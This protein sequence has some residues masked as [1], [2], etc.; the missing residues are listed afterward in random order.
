MNKIIKI[1]L[2]TIVLFVLL[3]L[4]GVHTPI[5]AKYI[6]SQIEPGMTR[7]EVVSIVVTNSI[8]K[9]DAC[10][11]EVDGDNK[12]FISKRAICNPP[13]ETYM[14]SGQTKGIK[15]TVLFMGPGFLHNDFSVK[16]DSSGKVV[17]I[18]EIKQWD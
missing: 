14:V 10:F 9:P 15:L 11:W 7:D 16:F 17:V 5:V 6:R 1:S 4:F 13:E 3:G 18:S 12:P 8:T 2:S